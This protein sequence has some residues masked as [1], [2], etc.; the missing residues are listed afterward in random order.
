MVLCAAAL[1]CRAATGELALMIAPAEATLKRGEQLQVE[2]TITN[3]SNSPVTLVLPGDGSQVGWRTPVVTWMFVREEA[4]LPDRWASLDANP[5]CGNINAFKRTEV[6][7]LEPAAKR[8]LNEWISPV[9]DLPAGRYRF[10]MQYSNEPTRKTGG[11]PR[12]PHE[13]GA[14]DLIRR[15]TACTLISNDVSVTVVE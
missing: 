7:A 4:A 10:R 8:S 12:G 2:A 1:I 15:S 14:E 3:S 11:L 6:F 5:I 9:V 13:A